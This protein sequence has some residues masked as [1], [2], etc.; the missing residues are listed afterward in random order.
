M[1]LLA[2]HY[3]ENH[4]LIFCF[5]SLLSCVLIYMC[6]HCTP[7]RAQS[8]YVAC[9]RLYLSFTIR[10]ISLFFV[11]FICVWLGDNDSKNQSIHQTKT[12][13]ITATHRR[14]EEKQTLSTV[15]NV[16]RIYLTPDVCFQRFEVR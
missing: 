11:R 10:M 12:K 2:F 14:E 6:V 8:M 13:T 4:L 16:S 1:L 15:G 9:V 3:I 5:H 7:Y